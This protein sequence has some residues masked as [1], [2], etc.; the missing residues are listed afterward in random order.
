MIAI[1]EIQPV[2]SKAIFEILSE[3]SVEL[4]GLSLDELRSIDPLS[5]LD[6][7]GTYYRGHGGAFMVILDDDYVVGMGGMLGLDDRVCEL[8][9]IFI[10]KEYRGRGLGREIVEE[11]LDFAYVHGYKQVRL[12]VATP[13]VQTAA[14][15]LYTHLDFT[16]IP[17][18]RAG[19]C[20]YAMGKDL[21]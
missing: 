2:H 1:V 21:P 6:E 15:A 11:L 19:P 8:K 16:E 13:D 5:D 18:Y 20:S 10:R 17:C 9:R 3:V 4:W 14:I 7:P 12:E